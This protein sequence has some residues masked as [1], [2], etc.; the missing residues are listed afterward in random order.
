MFYKCLLISNAQK[1]KSTHATYFLKE[2]KIITE[3][4]RKKRATCKMGE[5]EMFQEQSTQLTSVN[6]AR[7]K[8]CTADIE[9][10]IHEGVK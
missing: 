6:Q 4:M 9:S 8:T 3:G 7:R 2:T 5:L 10:T 1:R